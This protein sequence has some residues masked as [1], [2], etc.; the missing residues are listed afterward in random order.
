[1]RTI[2]TQNANTSLKNIKGHLLELHRERGTITREMRSWLIHQATRCYEI[3][4]TAHPQA[5]GHSFVTGIISNLHINV[6]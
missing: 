6:K 4:G 1:M 3:Q 2:T 5:C